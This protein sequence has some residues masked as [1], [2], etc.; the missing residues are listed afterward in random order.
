M[1]VAPRVAIGLCV[2]L[3]GAA[4]AQSPTGGIEALA[5]IRATVPVPRVDAGWWRIAGNPDL[6]A[7]TN[8]G[9][10]PVDFAIW[11]AADGMWQLW[12]CIRHTKCGGQSRLFHRWEG[13]RPLARPTT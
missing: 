2:L 12:S 5:A 3:A 4:R 13:R 7:L 8:A 9:Q 11:Q 10:Q 1:Q 6:G